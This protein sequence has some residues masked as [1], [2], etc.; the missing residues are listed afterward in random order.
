M[1][2]Q[3]RSKMEM[4]G[5]NVCS[6]YGSRLGIRP[7]VFRLFFIYT[8]FITFGS[9]LI[10]YLFMAFALKIKDYFVVR[11]RSVFDI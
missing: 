7:D 8:S 4:Y 5:F 3:L 2:E 6:R 1:I 10:I 11:K 9:P